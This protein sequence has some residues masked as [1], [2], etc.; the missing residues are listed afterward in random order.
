MSKEVQPIGK[1]FKRLWHHITI[2]RRKQMLLIVILMLLASVL[3]IISIGVVIPF[4]AILTDPHIILNHSF[5]QKFIQSVDIISSDQ[6]LLSI[7]ILFVIAIIA[8][9][10]VRLTLL[11]I[12]TKFSYSIGVDISISIYRKTL[13]QPYAVH[14]SRNSSEI[15]NGISSKSGSAI[16]II[17]TGLF[18]INAILIIILILLTLL[19]VEPKIALATFGGFGLIYTIIM[20]LTRK[21]QLINS[22][23]VAIE[24]TKVIKCLQEGLGGIRDVLIDGS[25]DI[26]C[27]IYRK[28]DQSLRLAEGNKLFI[29]TFPRAGVETLGMLFIVG[30]RK[31]VV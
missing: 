6:L 27:D 2:N 13:Y 21:K 15:I 17:N 31:S 11:W 22:Q 28:A 4:L 23:V 9:G 26:Y 16:Y 25:Q 10:A 1:L 12:I 24:S 18:L 30:D 3:E 5:Y 14:V 19:L 8:A 7:T 20:V 29:S